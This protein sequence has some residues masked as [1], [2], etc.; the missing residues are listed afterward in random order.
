MNVGPTAWPSQQIFDTSSP[1]SEP[2]DSKE[3]VWADSNQ[4]GSRVHRKETMSQSGEFE[5]Q[6]KSTASPQKVDSAYVQRSPSDNADRPL[7]ASA[8]PVVIPVRS[9]YA[10]CSDKGALT[11]H[12]I[13]SC[14][15]NRTFVISFGQPH[16]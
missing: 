14:F 2:A 5:D 8:R 15:R 6:P 10:P 16:E 12:F 7:G 3:N 1:S 9:I 13:F 4:P 11:N